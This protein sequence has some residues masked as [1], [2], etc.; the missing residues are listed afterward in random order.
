MNHYN[1]QEDIEYYKTL[2]WT[3]QVWK[4]T[5]ALI[6]KNGFASHQYRGQKFDPNYLTIDPQGW[7]HDH[8]ELCSNVLCENEDDGETTGFVS[9]NLWLCC[10][11]Y[12]S[13]VK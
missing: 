2:E 10:R 3:F 5:P 7:T 6:D 8:C 12:N 9:D 1:E 13:F 4:P 11:C